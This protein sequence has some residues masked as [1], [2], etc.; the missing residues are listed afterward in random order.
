MSFFK[1][2]NDRKQKEEK[3]MNI[4]IAIALL[5]VGFVM[6]TKGADW[7]VDGSSAL[8]FRLGIPRL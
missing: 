2:H 1:P 4:F 7:F 6:L 3:T 5:I 8:A